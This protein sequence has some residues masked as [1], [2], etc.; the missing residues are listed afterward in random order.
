MNIVD[1]EVL[2]DAISISELLGFDHFDR[3]LERDGV[4]IVFLQRSVFAAVFD[5]R[6][7][8]TNIRLERFAF[9][10]C[11]ELTRQ[12]EQLQTIGE[13]DGVHLLT[14]AQSRKARLLFVVASAD[15]YKGAETA[16]PNRDGLAAHRIRAKLARLCGF[17]TRDVLFRVIDQV[18][19]RLP[20]F[21]QW[22]GP[23][24][25]AAR[26]GIELIFHRR[27]EAVI[28]VLAEV[29]A[30]EVVDDLANVG[31]D[32][33][34]TV[35]IDVFAI[36]Q[37]RDDRSVGRRTTDTMFFERLDERG[38]GVARRRLGEMLRAAQ[39]YE[40]DDVT[41]LHGRE[42]AIVIIVGCIVLTFEIDGN[43]ARLDQ[44]RA[45]GA[46]QVS[47]RPFFAGEQIDGYRIKD[48]VG[49]LTGNRSF[50]DERIEF[51]KVGIDATLEHLRQHGRRSRTNGF[52]RLLGIA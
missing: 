4:W 28:D 22:L 47:I 12:L 45:I 6:T 16:H 49:H 40:I 11:A 39:A 17:V 32:E 30:Q 52:V 13:R 35:H 24:L 42:D 27:S 14:G 29:R 21:L 23:R 1:A 26:D 37:G 48:R 5:V 3:A 7:E 33:A 2:D 10:I 46:K 25:F 19:E 34:P 31:S 18:D 51:L 8:A 38:F 20:E 44:G 15:L 50:P 41:F 36:F 9:G 43:E